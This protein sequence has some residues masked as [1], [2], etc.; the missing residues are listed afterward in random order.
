[1]TAFD[2]TPSAALVSEWKRIVRG[3]LGDGYS[4]DPDSLVDKEIEALAYVCA[5]LDNHLTQAGAELHAS[6][7]IECIDEHEIALS[8]PNDAATDDADRIARVRAVLG[9]RGTTPASLGRVL[10][11][12]GSMGPATLVTPVKTDTD[13]LS[14][15][16][17]DEHHALTRYLLVGV[18]DYLTPR[19]R[20]ALALILERNLDVSAFGAN[21]ASP[22]R[23][24]ATSEGAFWQSATSEDGKTQAWGR[25]TLLGSGESRV[26]PWRNRSRDFGPGTVLH[27]DDVWKAAESIGTYYAGDPDSIP[28]DVRCIASV[29]VPDATTVTIESDADW[30]YRLI[31][32]SGQV[33]TSD[34]RPGGA[35]EDGDAHRFGPLTKTHAMASTALTTNV[36]LKVSALGALQIQNTSGSTQYV[37]IWAHA[38]GQTTGG[39]GETYP[40]PDALADWDP[41]VWWTFC[42]AFSLRSD[43]ADAWASGELRGCTRRLSMTPR[44]TVPAS[45]VTEFVLDS[46]LD[47]RDRFVLV[48]YGSWDHRGYAVFPGMRDQNNPTHEPDQS[49][50]DATTP[51]V[52]VFGYTGPGHA[53]AVSSAGTWDVACGSLVAARVYVD[54]ATGDLVLAIDSSAGP[55]GFPATALVDIYAGPQTGEHSSPAAANPDLVVPFAGDNVSPFDLNLAQD[56]WGCDYANGGHLPDTDVEGVGL[57]LDVRGE[58]AIARIDEGRRDLITG[59][60]EDAASPWI[61]RERGDGALRLLSQYLFTTGQTLDA[62]HDWRDRW[63]SIV[64]VNTVGNTQVKGSFYSGPGTTKATVDTSPDFGWCRKISATLWIYVDADTGALMATNPSG[65]GSQIGA[66]VVTSSLPLG[67]HQRVRS[68]AVASYRP[69]LSLSSL[70]LWLTASRCVLSTQLGRRVGIDESTSGVLHA[71]TELNGFQAS[72]AAAVG[73]SGASPFVGRAFPWIPG[74]RGALYPAIRVAHTGNLSWYTAL[75]AGT[76]EFLHKGPCTFVYVFQQ[77]R[78]MPW[79]TAN[80]SVASNRWPLILDHSYNTGFELAVDSVTGVPVWVRMDSAAEKLYPARTSVLDGRVHWV[81][82]RQ[83][84]AAGEIEIYV[85]GQI[86]NIYPA[87]TITANASQQWRI[88]MTAPGASLGG[89]TAGYTMAAHDLHEIFAFNASISD[90]QLKQL[91]AELRRVYRGQG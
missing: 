30:R 82:V 42:R 23:L 11:A 8:L 40:I 29:T 9:A 88:G 45:G 36:V 83:T 66:I 39:T 67:G 38:T 78:G 71:A 77:F 21:H 7:A 47:W 63:I 4:E 28:G 50:T 87:D 27:R 74:K 48:T 19:V 6:T 20:Q 1:M 16:S 18:A 62:D 13:G 34:L 54:S 12:L 49:D 91:H 72:G 65:A 22:R 32:F 55:A 86:E 70:Y 31:T 56:Y 2:P 44:F 26:A 80:A 41:S 58:P 73:F 51:S 17:Y 3:Q 60:A 37:N 57:G 90:A 35:A 59:Y 46:S 81:T 89:S 53:R 43:D 25:T 61:V 5:F 33:Y 10:S 15:S 68:P 52:Q 69:A 75:T 84:S 76:Y 64:G 14:L 24:L 85:D 79:D